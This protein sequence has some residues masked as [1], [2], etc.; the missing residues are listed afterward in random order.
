[1]PNTE[2]LLPHAMAAYYRAAKKL[3]PSAQ[4]MQPSKDSD[5]IH[6]DGKT[7]AHLVNIRGTLAVYELLPS[8]RIKAMQ[9]KHWPA[10]LA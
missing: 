9:P 1:M 5:V 8:G 10:A 7:L 2:T 6:I 3:H 4:A